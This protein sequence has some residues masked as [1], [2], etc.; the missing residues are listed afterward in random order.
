MA[1]VK[2]TRD[3][4]VGVLMLDEPASLNAM[5]PDLL[6]AL[7][8]AV[9]AMTGDDGIRALVLTGEGRG[10]CSGQNLKASEALGEDIA[11]GVMRFYWPAF[12]AL[13]ECRVPVVVAV[14]GV[15][16]GGGFSLAMAGDMIVAARSAS[17]IQVFSRIGLVPDLGSTW[18]LPRLVGRQRALE[19]MLLNEP[20][21]AEAAHQMGLV[22]KVVDDA[23]LMEEA[24][25]LAQR[26]ADGP[27]RALVATRALLEE[28]EHASY[29]AQFRREIELQASIRKS[30]D[31]L[32]GRNAFVEK[33]KAKFT[34]R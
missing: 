20:L 33:R 18:L 32:E 10:F 12:K 11:A 7:A 25:R 28:S 26:L 1:G 8:D 23:R 29:E 30:A 27:T 6:G 2:R 22:R 16:A 21:T 34:G 17:F 15:A 3:G 24:M 5:T 19:L 13:R 4:A 31:A 9:A 14:N